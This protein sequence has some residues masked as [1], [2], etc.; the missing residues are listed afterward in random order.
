MTICHSEK[1]FRLR[2]LQESFVI[3][4]K[5]AL[6][7]LDV[8]SESVGLKTYRCL[9]G[10]YREKFAPSLG[11][12][13]APAHFGLSAAT[14]NLLFGAGSGMSMSERGAIISGLVTCLESKLATVEMAA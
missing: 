11:L 1:L 13:D 5:S 6:L 14:C 2:N 12:G 10:F 9:F 8:V 4:R 3:A 7:D